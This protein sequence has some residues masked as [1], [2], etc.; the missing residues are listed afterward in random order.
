MYHCDLVTSVIKN[1][2]CVG[3]I[4]PI[5]DEWQLGNIRNRSLLTVLGGKALFQIAS[6][7][8]DIVWILTYFY[9]VTNLFP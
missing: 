3:D 5:T 4:S 8:V 7:P 9:T 2:S 1:K 6:W